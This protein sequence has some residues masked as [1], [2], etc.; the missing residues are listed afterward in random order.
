VI[1]LD[2]LPLFLDEAT[3]TLEIWE[4]NCLNLDK[5]TVSDHFNALF[6]AAHNLKGSSRSVGLEAY[7]KFVHL[8]EDC[9]SLAQHGKIPWNADISQ[10]LL[11]CQSVLKDWTQELRESAEY[12]PNTQEIELQLYQIKRNHEGPTSPSTPSAF[13]WDDGICFLDAPPPAPSTPSVVKSAPATLE[14]ALHHPAGAT[15]HHKQEDSIRVSLTKLDSVVRLLGALAIQH[16][17]LTDQLQEHLAHRHKGSEALELTQKLLKELQQEVLSL[18][19][20]PLSSLFQRLERV[21][22]DVARQQH[23][24]IEIIQ[25]GAETELDKNIIDKMKDPLVHILRNAVDHGIEMPEKRLQSSKPAKATIL[26]QGSQ[27]ASHVVITIKDDG[28]GLNTQRIL[29]KAIEKGLI[30]ADSQL[31]TKEIFDLIFKPGFSTA[32]NV[33]D[34]SGRGVGMDVVRKTLDDLGGYVDVESTPGQG[35]SFDIYIPSSMGSI[36]AIIVQE[37]HQ[38][39]AIALQDVEEIVDLS[40][41]IQSHHQ[42]TLHWRDEFIAMEP[43]GRLLNTHLQGNANEV[44]LIVKRGQKKVAISTQKLIGKRPIFVS[45]LEGQLANLSY[46]AGFTVLNNGQATLILQIPNL[47]NDI[48]ARAS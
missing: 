46:L 35:T 8:A 27:T 13:Q 37:N 42:D 11:Q 5:H 43:L 4:Q 22:I 44:G 33:T 24:E 18:R 40:K 3:D 14:P 9:I 31:S 30:S 12:V 2:F 10:L 1:D 15:G 17:Q 47:A 7:A 26:V 28:Q 29:K 21:A 39:Y 32:E 20:Q 19:L 6:R 34:V 36:D 45:K 25:V 23:K 48:L 38:L 16:S 41:Y